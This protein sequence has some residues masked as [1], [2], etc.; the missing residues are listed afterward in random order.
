MRNIR[1]LIATLVASVALAAPLAAQ[2]VPSRLPE[3]LN[4]ADLV[5]LLSLKDAP[6]LLDV[7]TAEE[8]AEGHIRGALL[9]PYDGLE[10]SF[11]E[12]D[13]DRPI[14]VYCRSGRRSAIARQ[15]LAKMGYANVA[16]F[17][18]ISNWRGELV[19]GAKSGS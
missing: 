6:L 13:K 2:V 14:V 18:G 8:Y 19:K 4:Y 11:A 17:G 12:K 5:R 15:S 10:S 7:R 16:D 9:A 1:I 3:K